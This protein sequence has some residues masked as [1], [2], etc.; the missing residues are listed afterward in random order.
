[1]LWSPLNLTEAQGEMLSYVVRYA[2]AAT[3]GSSVTTSGDARDVILD[4]LA[5]NGT[6]SVTVQAISTAGNG[7]ISDPLKSQSE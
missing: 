4:G 5:V 1:M 2:S 3:V 7:I 6:Y